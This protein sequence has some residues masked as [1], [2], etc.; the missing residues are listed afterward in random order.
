M[1]HFSPYSSFLFSS[2]SFFFLKSL[3]RSPPLF[4]GQNLMKRGL[5][6]GRCGSSEAFFFFKFRINFDSIDVSRAS[7]KEKDNGLPSCYRVSLD[8]WVL[9][10]CIL[11]IDIIPSLTS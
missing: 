4:F 3:Q 8:Y 6:I 10:S 2:L 11:Y 1:A 7:I 5:L 9:P